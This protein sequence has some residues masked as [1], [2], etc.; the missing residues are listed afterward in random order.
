MCHLFSFHR[1][2][3]PQ[4]LRDDVLRIADSQQYTQYK[5]TLTLDI[6]L[7]GR[8]RIDIKIHRT[9]N[10]CQPKGPCHSPKVVARVA[11]VNSLHFQQDFP[12]K[13]RKRGTVTGF[14]QFGSVVIFGSAK[15]LQLNM[16][17][18]GQLAYSIFKSIIPVRFAVRRTIPNQVKSVR[19]WAFVWEASWCA[20]NCFKI[21][22]QKFKQKLV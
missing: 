14:H 20:R 10:Q 5:E 8:I 17:T 7:N 18:K 3:H 19:N 4:D 9:Q 13:N 16:I 11:P 21:F 2:C 22:L 12:G 15:V 6:H 1:N